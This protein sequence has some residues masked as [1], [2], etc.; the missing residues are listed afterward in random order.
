M[1]NIAII[2]LYL[3]TL[4]QGFCAFSDFA[5][6]PVKKALP[7][8]VI[9]SIPKA[10]K[11]KKLAKKQKELVIKTAII[12]Q[13]PDRN[14]L[15]NKL[16]KYQEKNIDKEA[17]EKFILGAQTQNP[18]LFRVYSSQNKNS[19][20]LARFSQLASSH[21]EANFITNYLENR[22]Y[23]KRQQ[24]ELVL[25]EIKYIEKLYQ[26]LK[27]YYKPHTRKANYSEIKEEIT[28]CCGLENF[29]FVENLLK[30]EIY[31]EVLNT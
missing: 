7:E 28:L 2:F 5:Q 22:N 25:N 10:K 21:T 26:K 16:T 24:Q 15:G 30:R 1:R 14:F 13:L 11:I 8:P 3:L 9:R 31:Y 17:L 12:W 18:E 6:L 23:R 4:S 19:E 27:E 20:L 29:L